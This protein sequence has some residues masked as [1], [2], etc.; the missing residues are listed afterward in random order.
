MIIGNPL[1]PRLR[2]GIGGYT[3]FVGVEVRGP[4]RKGRKA[5]GTQRWQEYI[6]LWGAPVMG[7]SLESSQATLLFPNY[8]SNSN[9]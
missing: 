3:A 2:R 5:R 7:V 8:S 9:Q 4:S 6:L 1:G